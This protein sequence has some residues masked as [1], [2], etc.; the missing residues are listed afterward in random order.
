MIRWAFFYTKEW[1]SWLG[2][3]FLILSTRINIS[4]GAYKYTWRWNLE[5]LNI[6]LWSYYDSTN[7][8][9][10]LSLDRMYY[11]VHFYL[12]ITHNLH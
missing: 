10:E 11:F 1:S 3:I 5:T 8:V 7:W 12:V 2:Q 4:S 9:W 6:Q